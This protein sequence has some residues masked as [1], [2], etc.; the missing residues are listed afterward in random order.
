MSADSL[1]RGYSI[2][3]SYLAE[4]ALRSLVIG[5]AAAIGL[6]A[7]RV[8]RVT[9]RLLVWTA[10]LCAALTM[11]LLGVFL[12]RLP[13]AVPA[14]PLVQR[15]Q[16]R[17][18]SAPVLV[19]QRER[20]VSI[21]KAA[22]QSDA[23]AAR[24]ETAI[25]TQGG[26][27]LPNH[28]V[29]PATSAT[30]ARSMSRPMPDAA[31][32]ESPSAH[33]ATFPKTLEAS[34]PTTKSLDAALIP[35]RSLAIPW[36]TLLLGIYLAG[37]MILF[38]RLLVGVCFS[39][40]LERSARDIDE[41]EAL[42]L[43]RF[44]SCIAGLQNAPRLKES[45]ALAVPATVGVA[46]SAILLPADWRSW[47]E[48]QLDAIL[49]H[50]VSHVA[51]RD[52]LTQML[53]LVHR[54][55]FWF[56][57]LGWWLDKQLTDLAEQA[58]DEAALA[59]GADRRRYAETLLGFFAQLQ[60]AR[61]RVW[62]QGVSMAKRTRAGSAE[63]RV[64]RI[65][66]WKGTIS[67][68]KSFAVALIA[69]V[70]PLVF[71]AASVHPFVASAQD[72][73][74]SDTKNVIMPGGPNAPALPNAPKG[75]VASGVNG[76]VTGAAP[77]AP[78]LPPGPAAPGPG[79]GVVNP[80]PMP[81]A[82]K[83]GVVAPAMPPAPK[84]GVAAAG[85]IAPA[86]LTGPMQERPSPSAQQSSIIIVG[87]VQ[88]GEAEL[89]RAQQLY[90]RATRQ[91]ISDSV[92]ARISKETLAAAKRAMEDA[93][94]ELAKAKAALAQANSVDL[95]AVQQE[96]T[97]ARQAIEEAN[98]MEA[99]AVGA[100][101]SVAPLAPLAS[102]APLAPLASVAPLAPLASVAP[103][104]PLASVASEQ[105]SQD[106]SSSNITI[107]G[108]SYTMGEGP[109]YVMIYGNGNQTDMSGTDED[110]HHALNLRR[111]IS[112]DFIWFERDEKS[113]VITDPDFI[114]KVKALF[115]P[116]DALSKQQDELG[117][118]QDELG[119]KQDALGEQ[120]DN[121][122]VKIRD[123][124]P[125][126]ERIRARLKEL[127]DDGGA[128]QTELG[129]LQ[130]ELG[131]LQSDVGRFQSQAGASQSDIGRQQSELGRQQSELGR[132]QGELGREQ[133]E[134]ARKASQQ[135]RGM[136]DDAIAKGIAKPE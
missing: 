84:G 50:E 120:M 97:R 115:A 32:L 5:C 81:P 48:E 39:R 74:Q 14:A 69:F 124:T 57:P 125:D 38:A 122:K 36:S 86:T 112:G 12:P 25:Y 17:L 119:A 62:W 30:F 87:S 83:G 59:G 35:Q 98:S 34:T 90:D 96:L 46:R 4:P 71:L 113:Y 23:I 31:K 128:T 66:A 136:F 68:K 2:F 63:R 91:F 53:S 43:L 134:I 61:G 93:Q 9:A 82:P 79:Q 27:S 52:G 123:I 64:D 21:S 135:L 75:G 6:A 58:S 111:K 40:R 127:Q 92:N 13:L 44:R 100:V 116:E 126:L 3:V 118:Q 107:N 42:R 72:K 65:L 130:S 99:R 11:P 102:V 117:R 60:A 78:A 132:R 16:A 8:K 121:V 70:A 85:P 41:R 103:L 106:Q 24:S 67:M 18:Y 56:S 73:P 15:L 54:A 29:R 10:V 33:K 131:Q 109:R 28:S 101:A 76:G 133:G 1:A 129:R 110:L 95:S 51:R 7:F 89:H 47:T 45:A 114:A 26:K 37:V 80:G 88:D 104:A 77:V 108:G 55:I 105:D 22:V 20:A 49:A 19:A 94:A